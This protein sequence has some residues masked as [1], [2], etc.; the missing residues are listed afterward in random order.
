MFNA[1]IGRHIGLDIES[2][3]QEETQGISALSKAYVHE[4]A[5]Y[6]P[7]GPINI[8]AGF[9]ENLPVPG[10][11]GMNGF[12]ENFVVKFDLSEL[13]FDIERIYRA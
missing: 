7:G 4:I 1:D 8:K 11:L 12:F 5:L 9:M 3:Q 6:V 13:A 2:G 10:L